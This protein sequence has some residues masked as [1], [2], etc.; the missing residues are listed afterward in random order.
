MEPTTIS[1]REAIDEGLELE[2]LP[3][4]WYYFEARKLLT[5]GGR[6]LT[7]HGNLSLPAL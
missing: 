7:D 6:Q 2:R 5:A 1:W 4:I 3:F